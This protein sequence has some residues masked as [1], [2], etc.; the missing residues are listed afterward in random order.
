MP[1]FTSYVNYATG[2]FT[3]A[4]LIATL[5]ITRVL[6][7]ADDSKEGIPGKGYAVFYGIVHRL[8]LSKKA[9]PDAG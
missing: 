1:D 8:S 6:P 9:A 7:P 2:I 3:A 5:L 4:S